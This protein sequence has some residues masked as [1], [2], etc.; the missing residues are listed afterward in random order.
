MKNILNCIVCYCA[1]ILL[2]CQKEENN[3]LSVPT[4]AS[5]EYR[6]SGTAATVD[7]TISNSSEGTEQYSDISLPWS[8][9]FTGAKGNFIYVSAQNNGQSGTV[10]STIYINGQSFKTATS[11]G[12]YVIATAS[13]SVP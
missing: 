5:V 12:A 2:G 11:S 9:K 6:V 10:T 4:T 1:L 7:L 8:L 3:F 13:G